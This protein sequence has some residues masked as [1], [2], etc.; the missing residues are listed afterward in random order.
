MTELEGRQR[1]IIEG[2]KPEID[3]GRFAAKRAVGETVVVEADIFTDG[4]DELS[5]VLRYRREEDQAWTEV[6]MEFL[7]NDRWRGAFP[8]TELGFYRYGLVAWVNAFKS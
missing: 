6:P 1:A 5:A 3:G 8:V 2:V 7:V 4:H